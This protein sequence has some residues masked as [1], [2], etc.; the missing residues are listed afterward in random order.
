[1]IHL[2]I[3]VGWLLLFAA[4]AFAEDANRVII[5]VD[6]LRLEAGDLQ[7][8]LEDA[9]VIDRASLTAKQ[10]AATVLVRRTLAMNSL[11]SLGGKAIDAIVSREI[12]AMDRDAQTR[13]SSLAKMAATRGVSLAALRRSLEWQIAWREYLKSRLMD[14]ALKMYFDSHRARYGGREYLV[15]QIFLDGNDDPQ[16]QRLANIAAELQS[17]EDLQQSFA[18]QARD[19][20]QAASATRGGEIGWVGMDGDLPRELMS[21]IRESIDD[22]NVDPFNSETGRVVGPVRSSLGYHLILVRDTR[23]LEA[24]WEKLTDQSQ[25]RRDVANALM[26]DLL[27][28]QSQ[29]RVEYAVPSLRL[30]LR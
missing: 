10:A 25:L 3:A 21:A 30:D 27:D 18:V 8:V 14:D 1:M 7:L 12:D 22:A 16:S 11:R 20:S 2:R 5:T 15:S 23:D 24:S 19:H 26:E 6:S 29:A 13:G 17:V 9:G 28:R 4:H